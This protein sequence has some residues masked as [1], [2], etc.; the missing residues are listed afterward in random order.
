MKL[1][2]QLKSNRQIP[3]S[4]VQRDT[5]PT[6]AI[7]RWVQLSLDSER[8]RINGLEGDLL[9]GTELL[10]LHLFPGFELRSWLAN[11]FV[12]LDEI[13][14]HL[15]SRLYPFIETAV[16]GVNNTGVTLEILGFSTGV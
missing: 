15:P 1:S 9:V 5:E 12:L 10:V 13:N 8:A 11:D 14:I 2:V 16:C 3:S 4:D 7:I 6:E